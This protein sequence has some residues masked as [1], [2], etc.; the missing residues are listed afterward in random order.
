MS[1]QCLAKKPVL[2]WLDDPE[3]RELNLM[4]NEL[5]QTSS[6]NL[7]KLNVF[8]VQLHLCQNGTCQL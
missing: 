8:K 6:A 3:E 7:K 1:N 5:I 2:L 4:Y